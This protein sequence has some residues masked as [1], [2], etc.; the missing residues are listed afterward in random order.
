VE[1]NEYVFLHLHIPFF[2]CVVLIC[3][4]V[5]SNTTAVDSKIGSKSTQEEENP[6]QKSVIE[7]TPPPP[8]KTPEDPK[9]AYNTNIRD[10]L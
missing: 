9:L 6:A 3:V 5:P 2:R 1:E 7:E 10:R 4:F 8:P